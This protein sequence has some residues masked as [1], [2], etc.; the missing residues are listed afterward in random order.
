MSITDRDQSAL[1]ATTA[2]D[3]GAPDGGGDQLRG[4]FRLVFVPTGGA[5]LFWTTDLCE[6]CLNHGCGTKREMLD[7]RPSS[8]MKTYLKLRSWQKDGIPGG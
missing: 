7:L 2:D 8:A 3:G 1:P 4:R 6:T 5:L